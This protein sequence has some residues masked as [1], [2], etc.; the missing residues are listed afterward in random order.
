MS[1][2]GHRPFFVPGSPNPAR[3]VRSTFPAVRSRYDSQ[4]NADLGEL[5]AEAAIDLTADVIPVLIME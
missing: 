3:I 1:G 2:S 5:A 4:R